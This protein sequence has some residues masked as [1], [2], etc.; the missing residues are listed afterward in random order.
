APFSTRPVEGG[1]VWKFDPWLRAGSGPVNLDRAGFELAW[2]NIL[3]PVLHLYGGRSAARRP[4]FDQARLDAL[5]ADARSEV[6]EGGGHWVHLD[7]FE[8]SLGLIR[9]FLA[10]PL[11]QAR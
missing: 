7:H 9:A 10:E 6:I 2:A 1:L 3:C 11:P 4:G 5:F 8:E